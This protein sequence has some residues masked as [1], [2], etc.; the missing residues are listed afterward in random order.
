MH[1]HL[2]TITIIALAL[3]AGCADSPRPFFF[4]QMTDP[5]F[6]M[7]TGDKGFEKETELFE[8][9]VREANRLKPAFVIITGDLISKP[10]DQAQRE[11]FLRICGMLDKEIPLYLVS[12][13]HDVGGEPTAE[14][15]KLYR[16][17]IGKDRFSFEYEG[18]YGVVLNSTV[19]HNPDSVSAEYDAQLLWLK[20]ELAKARDRQPNHILIFLHHPLFLEEPDER[21]KYFNLPIERR[22]VYLDLLRT[23]GVR[24]V[25]A[26]HY[27]RNGY[28]KD[29]ALEMV[30]TGPVGRPLGDDPSGF[31]IVKVYPDRI[32]H[33][34][35]GLDAVPEKIT[36]E[37]KKT[38]E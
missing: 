21:D 32:E 25:F 9:A 2:Y 17:T 1:R 26:G 16:E 23:Y 10:G 22:K 38:D 28:G 37:A 19:I 13:N 27:H 18:M 34:Y 24:L 5:Q 15:L 14:S 11:E 7:F 20:Q 31:R 33:Q 8:K 3:T 30:T 35:Y 6:G 29:G 4:I 12:G 36:L